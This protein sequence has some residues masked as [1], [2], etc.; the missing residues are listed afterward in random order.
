MPNYYNYLST[1]LR[2][3]RISCCVVPLLCRWFR[4]V[5]MCM[6]LCLSVFRCRPFCVCDFARMHSLI[7]LRFLIHRRFEVES[8]AIAL[9]SS[10]ATLIVLGV[11]DA[12]DTAVMQSIASSSAQYIAVPTFSELSSK[13]SDLIQL[14]CP[15]FLPPPVPS[16]KLCT[17][18]SV[19]LI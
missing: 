15:S 10:G 5:M 17:C 19:C 8:E 2:D 11:T 18:S 12:V 7:W 1:L 4:A 14:A 6:L 9:K 3:L 13:R 16:C